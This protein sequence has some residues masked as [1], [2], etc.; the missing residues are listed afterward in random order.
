MTNKPVAD[1][2]TDILGSLIDSENGRLIDHLED[3][4]S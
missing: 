2:L 4:T 3:A 1:L